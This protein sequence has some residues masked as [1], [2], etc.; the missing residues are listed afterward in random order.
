MMLRMGSPAPSIKVEDW[1]RGKPLA[2]FQPGKVYIVEFWASWCELCAAEMLDLMQLQ[3]KYRDSGLEVVAVA[4]NEDAPTAV[5]TRSKLDAWLTEKCAN[6]NYRIAF[7]YTGEM[8]KL[9]MKPSFCVGIPTSFVVDRDGCIAFIGHPSQLGEVLPKV[10]NGS[11]RTSN[12]AKAADQQR[13]ATSEPL[14]R[15]QALKKPIDDRFWA[16]VEQE[17]WKRALTAIEE[18][19]AFM[20]DDLSFRLAHAHLLLHQIQDMW[21][22][23]PVMRQ[24]VRDAIDKNS[25]D[26]MVSA[27]DQL[28]HPAN[29]HSRLPPAERFAM[30]KELSENIMAL[31][32]PQG[33]SPKFRSYPAV[34]RYYHENGNN[35]RAIELVEL[36]LTSLDSPEPILAELKEQHLP[37]LLQALANYRGGNVCYGA[38]YAAPQNNFREV[39]KRVRTKKNIKPRRKQKRVMVGMSTGQFFHFSGVAAASRVHAEQGGSF[40]AGSR[41]ESCDNLQPHR[42]RSHVRR[43]FAP[44]WK[45]SQSRTS[46]RSATGTSIAWNRPPRAGRRL[47]KCARSRRARKQ[48]SSIEVED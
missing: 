46:S 47:R 29:D 27:L 17:D 4:A 21:T 39:P 22:G 38:L 11:W 8:K 42:G 3:E 18:G 6:L 36:A 9:S 15:E 10:L 34:A 28:F 5:E 48:Q 40:A 32:P 1:L 7:D 16:A 37:D 23:L 35:D 33:D 43:E 45:T 2:N 30:G 44:Q 25:E 26:W 20:P 12:K 13:I 24:L 14:A 31:N 19:I 41:L